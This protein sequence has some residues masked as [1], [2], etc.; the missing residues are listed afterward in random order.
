[1][2]SRLRRQVRGSAGLSATVGFSVA[3]FSRM[4]LSEMPFALTPAS[5]RVATDS[6]AL[7][8]AFVGSAVDTAAATGAS[9]GLLTM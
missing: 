7:E 3:V 4:A 9:A 8:S 5:G 2:P 1:M 6:D